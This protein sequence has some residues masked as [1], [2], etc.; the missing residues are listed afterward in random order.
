MYCR[1]HVLE[2]GSLV[3]DEVHLSDEG[4]YGCTAGN[5]GG[6]KRYEV[7][8]IVRSKYIWYIYISLSLFYEIRTKFNISNPNVVFKVNFI[9]RIELGNFMHWNCY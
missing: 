9:H 2:N 7:S 3:I 5:S 4:K 8:L 1:F 6:L